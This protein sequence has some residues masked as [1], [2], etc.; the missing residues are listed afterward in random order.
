MRQKLVSSDLMTALTELHVLMPSETEIHVF[1]CWSICVNVY[2]PLWD[3]FIS[4]S[5][6]QIIAESS[7]WYYKFRNDA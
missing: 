2:E 5:E 1:R 4:I 7:I 6:K 3:I